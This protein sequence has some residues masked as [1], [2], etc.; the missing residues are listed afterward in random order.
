M[1]QK[2]QDKVEPGWPLHPPD[3]DGVA[4]RCNMAG[5]ST[6]FQLPSALTF[7]SIVRS[8]QAFNLGPSVAC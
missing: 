1:A 7:F 4:L 6:A 8:T 5:L 2:H 3:G